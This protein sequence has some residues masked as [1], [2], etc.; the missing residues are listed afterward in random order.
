MIAHLDVD[1]FFA[2]VEE[3]R[4]SLRGQP[5]GVQQNMDVA[6]VNYEARAHGLYNRISVVEAKRRCPNIALTRG[7]N[8]DNGDNAMQRYRLAGQAILKCVM[9]SLDEMM[10]A[11]WIGRPV[12]QASFDDFFVRLPDGLDTADAA[13]AWA[14]SLRAAILEAT[15]L[16]CSVG[17]ARTK[18]LSVLATKRAKPDGVH[19]CS[20]L[21]AEYALL[22]DARISAVRGAGLRGICPSTRTALLR[23]LGEEATLG[24]ARA[25]LTRDDS[26][27]AAALEADEAAALAALLDGACDG[28]VVVSFAPPKGLSV[29]CSVRPT[30][31]EP[32][33]SVEQVGRGFAHL[34]LLLLSRMDEYETTYGTRVALRLVVK[35]KLFPGA[36]ETRQAQADWPR[37]ADADALAA[38]ACRTFASATASAPFRVSRV[39]LALVYAAENQPRGHGSTATRRSGSRRAGPVDDPTQP[40]IDAQAAAWTAAHAPSADSPSVPSR[41]YTDEDPATTIKGLGFRDAE[42]ARLTI[43]LASQPGCS[44]KRYWSIKAMAERARHHAA[45]TEGMRRALAIFDEWLR[46]PPPG[47]PASLIESEHAQR[48]LLAASCA[49]AHGLS[50]CADADEFH[51][52]AVEDKHDGLCRVREGAGSQTAFGLPPTSFV[53]VFG[54]PGEHGYGTHTCEAASA[55]GLPLYRCTCAFRGA[56]AIHVTHPVCALGESALPLAVASGFVLRFDGAAAPNPA[57]TLISLV[58][59][60]QASLRCFMSTSAC[61]AATSAAASSATTN[62]V[63]NIT[64]NV[65]AFPS[66]RKRKAEATSATARPDVA[67]PR[68]AANGSSFAQCPSCGKSVPIVTMNSHLDECLLGNA[69]QDVPLDLGAISPGRS[70]EAAPPLSTGVDTPASTQH[71]G[72]SG[73]ARH[74]A[75]TIYSVGHSNGPSSALLALLASHGI[76]HLIDVR[77]VPRSSYSPQFNRE[78]LH[79]VCR[80]QSIT[81]EHHGQALGGKF[82]EGGVTGRLASDEGRTALASLAAR[83]AATTE[84]LALMCSEAKWCECHRAA[85]ARE[86]VARYGCAVLHIKPSGELECHPQGIHARL[87]RAASARE[88]LED[89]WRRLTTCSLPWLALANGWPLTEDHCFMRIALDAAFSGCWYDHLDKSRPAIRQISTADLGKAVAAVRRIEAEGVSALV[90]LNDASFRWRGKVGRVAS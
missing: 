57:V 41:L 1:Y 7:D 32:A 42:V 52:R 85:L 28:S 68:R 21:H 73:D 84:R 87:Q 82:V 72:A 63:A 18:L 4:L 39:E 58:P 10:P 79:E 30:D 44:Y 61:A 23:S 67:P 9:G 5:L 75:G 53:A 89:E 71:P 76:T 86:L 34:A 50:R 3:V 48:R 80:R 11:C 33:V 6:A 88:A 51:R 70:S 74:P 26:G 65:V 49:N 13:L 19:C 47:P 15:G 59:P 25:W 54:G 36:T 22:D 56:H 24:E 20:N 45:P 38:L 46:A 37:D 78:A 29:E 40:R 16:R 60:G 81:Y 43:K 14:Q 35:W 62:A 8:G 64:A 27:I 66:P 2:Q 55:S 31:D 77:T 90:E 83:A 17:L 12:E 69:A